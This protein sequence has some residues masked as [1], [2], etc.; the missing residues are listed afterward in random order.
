MNRTPNEVMGV[1]IVLAALG[2]GNVHNCTSH[3]GIFGI[4]FLNNVIENNLWLLA[5]LTV[6]L[7]AHI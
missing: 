4:H 6:Q 1:N 7:L 5:A 2:L 3:S